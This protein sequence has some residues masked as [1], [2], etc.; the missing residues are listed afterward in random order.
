MLARARKALQARHSA[1]EVTLGLAKPDSGQQ[2]HFH[3]RYDQE[4]PQVVP[5][6]DQEGQRDMG[7]EQEEGQERTVKFQPAKPPRQDR[8]RRHRW[9]TSICYESFIPP[10][11]YG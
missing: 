11:L 8:P 6:R 9:S 5:T 10:Q 3:Y 4:D 7:Q 2:G 1:S